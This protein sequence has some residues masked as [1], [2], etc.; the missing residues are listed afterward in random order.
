MIAA[1]APSRPSRRAKLL[2]VRAT[3]RIEHWP[4]S[5]LPALLRPTDL[6]IANDAATLP[7]SLSGTHLATGRAIEVRLAGRDSLDPD[8]VH[9]F[10]AVVFGGGDH[11]IRTE[12]RPKPPVLSEGDQM[13][14]GPLRAVVARLLN[15]PRLVLLR[16]DA[17]AAEIWEGLARHGKPIQY[18]HIRAPLALWDVWTALA[19]PPVAF[20]APSAGF[21][22]SWAMLASLAARGIRLEP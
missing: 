5:A 3:G 12:A 7:A 13:A 6:L 9:E 18:S 10:V 16:L 2:V 11:R 14:L 1:A 20:E 21:A 19:G 17:S 8:R 22:L 15:H 4:R